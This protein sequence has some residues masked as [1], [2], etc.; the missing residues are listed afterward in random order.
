MISLSHVSTT[1]SALVLAGLGAS[2]SAQTV[3]SHESDYAFDGVSALYDAYD[4]YSS[5]SAVTFTPS[6]SLLGDSSTFAWEGS[7][8]L[9]VSNVAANGK[10]GSATLA[11]TGTGSVLSPLVGDSHYSYASNAGQGLFATTT[12]NGVTT[13]SLLSAPADLAGPNTPYTLNVVLAGDWTQGSQRVNAA[14]FGVASN[15]VITNNFTFD[16]TNTY[17]SA[18]S[19]GNVAGSLVPE[20]GSVALLLGLTFSG[21]ALAFRRRK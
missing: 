11:L 20:P 2:A 5:P 13:L 12:T 8:A 6:V 17:F 3:I 7:G 9:S 16:G 18:K 14:S 19:N 21:A 4:T 15:F 10:T 1:L